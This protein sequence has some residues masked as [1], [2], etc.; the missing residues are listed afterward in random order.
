ML[1]QVADGLREQDAVVFRGYIPAPPLD[2]FVELFWYY[3]GRSPKVGRELIL[4]NGACQFV[5]RLTEPFLQVWDRDDRGFCTQGGSILNGAHSQPF[6]IDTGDQDA[7]FGVQFRVG[8]AFPFLGVPAVELKNQHVGL[9][10]LWG[11]GADELRTRLIEAESV[12]AKF[13]VAE[14]WLLAVASAPLVRHRSVRFGMA[15][16]SDIQMAGNVAGVAAE[17]GLSKR[18]FIELFRTQVGLTPKLFARVRRFQAAI[19]AI[20]EAAPRVDWPEIALHCGYFDQAHFI[21]DFKQFCGLTP[22]RYMRQRGDQRNHV[23]FGD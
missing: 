21:R 9:A 15:R 14:R 6:I 1:E 3:E 8:G 17:A 16:L 19:D 5:I 10:E 7:L 11:R 2:R 18:R 22:G 12:D 13:A 23:R 20:A 4:P